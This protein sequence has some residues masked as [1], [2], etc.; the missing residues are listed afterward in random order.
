MQFSLRQGAARAPVLFAG[1]LVLL[2]VLLASPTRLVAQVYDCSD[3]MFSVQTADAKLARRICDVATAAAAR[4]AE[5]HLPQQARITLQVVD[6]YAHEEGSCLGRYASA[7]ATLEISSIDI[8]PDPIERDHVFSRI[9]VPELFDSVIVHELTHALLH[10][11]S[12]DDPHCVAN[13]EYMAYAMQMQTFSP[14]SRRL[15]IANAGG[16]TD[17]EQERLNGF[18]AQAAPMKFAAWSWLHFSE[19]QNGCDFFGKLLSRETTL[20]LPRF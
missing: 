13:H 19:P 4:L 18:I 7:D 8:I 20:E 6:R 3:P 17:V 15:I 5:C 12:Y 1:V 11:Q 10:Q 14:A 16:R 9:P 2:V